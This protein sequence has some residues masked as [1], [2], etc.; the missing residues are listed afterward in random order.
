M[1]LEACL[2]IARCVFQIDTG[3]GVTLTNLSREEV[4]HAQQ[5][6]FTGFPHSYQDSAGSDTGT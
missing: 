4:G 3:V 2:H 6:L 1:P 5:L